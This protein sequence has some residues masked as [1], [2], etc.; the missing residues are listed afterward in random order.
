MYDPAIGQARSG[1][2][3]T[4]GQFSCTTR[5][6]DQWRGTIGDVEF[7]LDRLQMESLSQWRVSS[8]RQRSE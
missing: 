2:G 8:S 1:L 4:I 7:P 5:R 3:A 6:V